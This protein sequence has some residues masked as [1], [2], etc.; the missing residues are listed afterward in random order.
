MAWNNS[1]DDNMGDRLYELIESHDLVILNDDYPTLLQRPSFRNPIINLT[2]VFS[3][4]VFLCL[5]STG[6]DTWES[7][8]FPIHTSI[9]GKTE[10]REQFKYKWMLNQAQLNEFYKICCNSPI[11]VASLE[12]SSAIEKYEVFI[13]NLKSKLSNVI[14]E[15]HRFPRSKKVSGQLVPPHWWN[16]TCQTAVDVT[17]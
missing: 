11:N 10:I 6:K 7:H 3:N 14:P 15:K 4:L 9:Y 2:L 12:G 5:S 16:D 13:N 8:H 1:F 17:K